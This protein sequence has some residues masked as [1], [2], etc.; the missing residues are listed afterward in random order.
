[1]I[2]LRLRLFE[3][4]REH[5]RTLVGVM[6][7]GLFS[8][9][10]AEWALPLPGPDLSSVSP[11]AQGWM[12][13][14]RYGLGFIAVEWLALAYIAAVLLF[15]AP[16]PA[17]LGRLAL[18]G[19]A[20]RMALTNY[21]IQA[22][23]L[24]LLF[25][26]YGFGRSITAQAAPLAALSLFGAEAFVSRWWLARFRYGPLEWIWR[27]VTYWRVQPFRQLGPAPTMLRS[28]YLDHSRP[29]RAGR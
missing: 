14:L 28:V 26:R 7:F 24:S 4:P 8:W 6:T 9:A 18:F 2:G 25:D 5:R 21:M 17:W 13:T 12:M 27:S 22:M 29:I 11:L 19:F 10:M 23:V 1:M 3:R 16:K 15:V 20:G